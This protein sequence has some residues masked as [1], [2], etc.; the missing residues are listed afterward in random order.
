MNAQDKAKERMAAW[1]SLPHTS[2]RC[3]WE[4]FKRLVGQFGMVKAKQLALSDKFR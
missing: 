3:S 4:T 1:K 2:T